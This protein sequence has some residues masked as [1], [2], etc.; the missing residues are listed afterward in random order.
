MD[1]IIKELGVRDSI[2][3]AVFLA[4]VTWFMKSV[5]IPMK[6]RHFQT[7][8]VVDAAIKAGVLNQ[9]STVARLDAI[10]R[11]LVEMKGEKCRAPSGQAA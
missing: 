11:T 7:M 5:V 2:W 6:D 1:E 8:D 9:A 4:A 3:A 10:D